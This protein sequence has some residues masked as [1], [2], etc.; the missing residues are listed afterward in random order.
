MID[1]GIGVAPE[2]QERIFD[3]FQQADGSSTRF[4]G[5]TGLGLAITR[6]LVEL[7]GGEFGVSSVPGAGS[8]FWFTAPLARAAEPD[9]MDSPECEVTAETLARRFPVAGYCWQKTSPSIVN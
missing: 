1:T 8:T 5:G 9:T 7:M 3:A 2:D 4:Y 6:E